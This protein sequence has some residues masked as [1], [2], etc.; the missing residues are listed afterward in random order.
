MLIGA[1]LGTIYAFFKRR[2]S[3]D[4]AHDHHPTF[5][6]LNRTLMT[7]FTW[8]MLALM[9]LGGLSM[10]SRFVRGLGGSTHLS[11]TVPLGGCGSCSISCGLRSPPARLPP[12]ASFTCSSGRI[13]I[14]SADRLSCSDS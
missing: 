9:A 6:T 4:A 10:V 13:C 2:T 11:N 12:R 8:A 3:P 1:L 5:E 7:P 14:R